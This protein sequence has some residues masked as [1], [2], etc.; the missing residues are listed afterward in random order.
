MYRIKL[1]KKKQFF[2]IAMTDNGR[3]LNTSESFTQKHSAWKNISAAMKMFSGKSV[4]VQDDSIKGE[5][6]VYTLL[7]NGSCKE[8]TKVKPRK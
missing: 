5:V 6:T 7:A 8:N 2:V 1:N 4:L 3:T